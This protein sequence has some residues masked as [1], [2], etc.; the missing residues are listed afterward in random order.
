MIILCHKCSGLL[1]GKDEAPK[2]AYSCGCI[3]GYVR[4]WQEPTNPRNVIAIQIAEQRDRLKL[5]DGQGRASNDQN[6]LRASAWLQE[7]D[8]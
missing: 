4:D 2:D 8:K 6:R 7:H 5:Y 1:C 3:S